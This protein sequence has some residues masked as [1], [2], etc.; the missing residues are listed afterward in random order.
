MMMFCLG[1]DLFFLMLDIVVF[2][3]SV[4]LIWIGFGKM[5]LF[6][7]RLVISVLSVVLVMDMLSINL[8]VKM[9]LMRI[10]LNLDLVVNLVFRCIGWVLCVSVVNSRLLVWVIVCVMLWWINFLVENW[11]KYFLGMGFF[12]FWWVVWDG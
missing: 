8:N 6:I 3:C 2:V 9:L 1:F 11:L 7:F 5:I 12:Y 10:W 4:L